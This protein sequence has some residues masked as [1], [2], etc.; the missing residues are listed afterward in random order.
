MT[1]ASI[2]GRDAE[3]EQLSQMVSRRRSFLL[4]G[5]AGVGKS[6]LLKHLAGATPGMLYCDD[7]SSSQMVFRQ[8]ASELFARKNQ[9][10]LHACEPDGLNAIASK[11]AVAIRGIVTEALRAGSYALV[12]D[13]LNSPSQSFSAAVKDVCNRA[14]SRLIAVARSEHME[15][16]GFLLPMFPNRSEKCALR[17]FDSNTAREFALQTAQEMQLSAT[18]RDEAIEK[19]VDY[20]KG[21]PGA[22]VAMLEMAANPRYVTH[23]HVKLS[24]LY[25]DFRLK[26]SARHAG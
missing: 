1:P 6:L 17:N 25:I 3:I 22:I 20:S 13:H 9:H 19:I 15:D 8:L 12:I 2:Y 24:P 10:V 4:Y 18:N 16:V 7:S 5:P 11:S 26:W 14:E 21:N 23:E